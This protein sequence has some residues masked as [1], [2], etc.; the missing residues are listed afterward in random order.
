MERDA[1]AD[2][3]PTQNICEQGSWETQL[4]GYGK[5]CVCLLSL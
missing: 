1:H 4:E 5:H 3:S 2:K